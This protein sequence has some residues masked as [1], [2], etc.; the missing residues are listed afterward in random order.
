MTRV[1][2]RCPIL[3][4]AT[5]R[6]AAR[7]GSWHSTTELRPRSGR[8]PTRKGCNALHPVPRPPSSW[9]SSRRWA[10]EQH[11][12]AS[13]EPSAN[14]ADLEAA[15]R[16]TAL[17]SGSCIVTAW[18]GRRSP[19]V[20]EANTC[21]F[22]RG[23]CGD[24]LP[25]ARCRIAGWSGPGP[26]GTLGVARVRVVAQSRCDRRVTAFVNCSIPRVYGRVPGSST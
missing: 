24:S 6:P 2:W 11:G 1:V 10:R 12:A 5:K 3:A 7:L 13:I 4:N 9:D 18:S 17:T 22:S 21:L 14:E 19:L 20:H 26:P 15:R 25:A 8:R 23:G 16:R